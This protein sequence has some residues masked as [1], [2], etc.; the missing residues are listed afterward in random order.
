MDVNEDFIINTELIRMELESQ[1]N[2]PCFSTKPFV[3]QSEIFNNP[4]VEFAHYLKFYFTQ[5]HY[6]GNA[7]L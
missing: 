7:D 3:H 6:Y 1:W 5:T 2:E 4:V